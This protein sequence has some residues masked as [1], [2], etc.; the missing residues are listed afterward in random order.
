MYAEL[1][2][3]YSAYSALSVGQCFLDQGG[4]SQLNLQ[5]LGVGCLPKTQSFQ[6][7]N[8]DFV[9]ICRYEK[10]MRK[11]Q[12]MVCRYVHIAR[13]HFANV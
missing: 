6:K 1:S 8:T 9:K 12:K 4:P 13:R 11:S 7:Q 2:H 10:Y 3:T 5:F